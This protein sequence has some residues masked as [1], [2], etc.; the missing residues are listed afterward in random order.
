MLG[1]GFGGSGVA[2]DFKAESPTVI[3]MC[4]MLCAA[5]TASKAA[6]EVGGRETNNKLTEMD[7][8]KGTMETNPSPCPC[9]VLHRG[10]EGEMES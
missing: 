10:G 8:A 6:S 5:I 4:L 9:S 7:V 1:G 2:G 3:R